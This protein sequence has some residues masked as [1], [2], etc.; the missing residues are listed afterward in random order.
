MLTNGKLIAMPSVDTVF[1][2]LMSDQIFSDNFIW[3]H[4]RKFIVRYVADW[5]YL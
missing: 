1:Y 3:Q 2:N 4:D 5:K